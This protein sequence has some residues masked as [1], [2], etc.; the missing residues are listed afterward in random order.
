M[1]KLAIAIAIAAS[2]SLGGLAHA[3][4]GS[5]SGQIKSA[6]RSGSADAIIAEL[7]RAERLICGA[8]VEPVL[9]LVDHA[10]YRVREAAAWWIARRPALKVEVR[11]LATARLYGE[12][13]TLARNGADALGTFRHPDAIPA[14]AFASSR[15]D[16]DGEARAAAVRALG[17]ITHRD[18]A[19]AILAAMGDSDAR[20]RAAAVTAFG[21]LRGPIGADPGNLGVLT[22][23]PDLSVR[24]L[25]TAM[26]GRHAT[27]SARD[28]LIDTLANDPDTLVRRN[29]AWALGRIGD[30]A[31]RPALE[32]AAASDPSRLVRSIAEAAISD[33]D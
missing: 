7:E 6:I 10:D 22:A 5:S 17:T 19:P 14:L 9:E 4:R 24:R 30:R 20:V 12:D 25:A 13:S 11:D 18:A 26:L 23:D 32:A 33:L 29:A 15:A 21:E 28:A 16:L 27:Q 31:A 3:G 8:C 2:L 1:R